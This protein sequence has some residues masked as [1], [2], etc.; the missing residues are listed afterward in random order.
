MAKTTWADVTPGA[1]V[2]LKGREWEVLKAKHKGK[3]V[4][5]TVKG[6][7]GEFDSAMK[8]TDKVTITEP[9]WAD[10]GA[11]KK[12]DAKRA[13]TEAAHRAP[14]LEPGRLRAARDELD[15]DETKAE[16]KVRTYLDAKLL[17][18]EVD[19]VYVMPFVS[20][21]TVAAHLLTFHG[22]TAEGVDLTEAKKLARTHSPE[23]AITLLSW[24]KL[25]AVHD[26]EHQLIEAGAKSALVDHLHTKD[27]PT[28]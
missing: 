2:L 7:G 9:G 28:P 20:P 24:D 3:A 10:G 4:K 21:D 14:A 18:V 6:P 15:R 25:K 1:T 22:V 17:A 5:V 19:G 11:A 26:R 13:K 27:R 12:A 8:A 16:R 23:G